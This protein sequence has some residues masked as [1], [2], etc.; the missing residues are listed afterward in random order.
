M[1]LLLFLLG[2]SLK[3]NSIQ[4]TSSPYLPLEEANYII[5]DWIE[6]SACSD[7]IFGFRIANF[8][9]K[10]FGVL[11]SDI[12]L[13]LQ[14]TDQDSAEALFNAIEQ[15]PRTTHLIYSRFSIDT[16][17]VLFPGTTRPFFG[18]R[19]SQLRAKTL[20]VGVGYLGQEKDPET[21]LKQKKSSEEIILEVQVNQNVPSIK[22]EEKLSV[23]EQSSEPI[24]IEMPLLVNENTGHHQVHWRDVVILNSLLLSPTE[25]SKCM[26][27]IKV[28]KNGLVKEVST[29]ECNYKSK[30]KEKLEA[31]IRSLEFEPYKP[32][33]SKVPFETILPVKHIK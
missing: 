23:N 21:S 9:K 27:H 6:T 16:G 24:S 15:Y 32:E 31:D 20:T 18:K 29:T 10:Q 8:Q 12:A 1:N 25:T 11:S 13:G 17:G 4:K 30:S 19:C 33:Y 14:V 3:M 5:G 2:C 28:D 26:A 7:Y 22:T